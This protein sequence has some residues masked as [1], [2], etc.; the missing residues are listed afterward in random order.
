MDIIYKLINKFF[1]EQEDNCVALINSNF[2]ISS[3]RILISMTVNEPITLSCLL[4]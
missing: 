4:M 3:L 2:K 1:K